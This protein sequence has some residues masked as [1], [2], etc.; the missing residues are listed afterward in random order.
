MAVGDDKH[1]KALP[2]QVQRQRPRQGQGGRAGDDHDVHAAAAA[3]PPGPPCLPP[4]CC[5][6]VCPVGDDAGGDDDEADENLVAGE[7][8]L[9]AFQ[10]RRRDGYNGRRWRRAGAELVG[11]PRRV[12]EGVPQGVG[13]LVD[14][15][16]YKVGDVFRVFLDVV[17]QGRELKSRMRASVESFGL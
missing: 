13:G 9:K 7:P 10:G 1:N 4:P 15:L 8:V 3:G 12:G 17:A 16:V 6:L 11:H 14:M 2:L 5:A